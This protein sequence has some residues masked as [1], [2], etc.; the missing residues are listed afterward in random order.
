[1]AFEG[2]LLITCLYRNYREF[3]L[4]TSN[5]HNIFWPFLIVWMYL[6]SA[7]SQKYL[8]TLWTHMG[9]FKWKFFIKIQLLYLQKPM[10]SF[11]N[12][13][14][15]LWQEKLA[16]NSRVKN[17]NEKSSPKEGK[18]TK[19]SFCLIRFVPLKFAFPSVSLSYDSLKCTE[20]EILLTLI[21]HGLNKKSHPKPQKSYIVRGVSKRWNHG[22]LP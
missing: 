3:T 11:C 20:D 14:S 22:I 8:L 21:C 19:S 4:N 10:F 6:L 9:C 5:L 12:W 1:M 17:L 18:Q 2:N 7:S 15:C 13:E 16:L